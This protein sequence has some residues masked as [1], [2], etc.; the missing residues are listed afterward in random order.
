MSNINLIT[1]A[2][3]YNV[4]R[5]WSSPSSWGIG[6]ERSLLDKSLKFTSRVYCSADTLIKIFSTLSYRI[7]HLHDTPQVSK[8]SR[9]VTNKFI[10]A[11]ISRIY[12]QESQTKRK[13]RNANDGRTHSFKRCSKPPIEEGIGPLISLHDISLQNSCFVFLW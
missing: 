10:V 13:M 7:L 4:I 6:P 5:F 1:W 9:Y 2:E 8:F 3:S 11:K 12:W